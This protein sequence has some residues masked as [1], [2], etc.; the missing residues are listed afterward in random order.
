L[1]Q[2]QNKSG[3]FQ[4]GQEYAQ[5]F[6]SGQCTVTEGITQNGGSTSNSCGPTS[7]C[8]IGVTQ[9]TTSEG[10]SGGPCGVSGPSEGGGCGVNFPFPPPSPC[11]NFCDDGVPG[12]VLNTTRLG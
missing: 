5:C 10:T 12:V 6:T 7:Q 2:S 8:N 4:D 11:L 1:N 9:T 3:G